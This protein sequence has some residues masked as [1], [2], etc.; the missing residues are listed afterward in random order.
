MT[1][2]EHK[3]ERAIKLIRAV[4]RV[5]DVIVAYSGGKDSDVIRFL[6]KMAGVNYTLVYNSTTI[7]PEYTISR[8]ISLGATIIR[9]RLSFF[10]LIKRKGLPNIQRRFCCST[11][12][13][14]FIAPRLL[15]GVRSA[16]SVKRSLRY[17]E[18]T[19]CRIYSSNKHC[20]QI[21]PIFDWT[22]EEIKTFIINNNIQLHPLYYDNG[23]LDITKR[24][25]CIGC[26]LQGDRGKADFLQYPKML[27]LWCRAYSEYVRTHKAINGVYE[28]MVYHLF[29]SNHGTIKYEQNFNGIFPAPNAKELLEDYF[30]VLL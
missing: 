1:E 23:I 11:L 26:P 6:C 28:D 2:L 3:V 17:V 13:E 15:L 22:L 10:E 24:L 12:K 19:A 25:G 29:Y 4:N 8:N 14:G 21:F 18:P 27:R 7:D 30:H 16:E 5:S 9:P 20:D